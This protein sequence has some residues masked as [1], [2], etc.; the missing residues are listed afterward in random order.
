[1]LIL[2]TESHHEVTLRE[3]EEVL[4]YPTNLAVGSEAMSV[5][6]IEL[7]PGIDM[8]LVEYWTIV[9]DETAFTDD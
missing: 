5:E 9:A 2:G 3:I 1:M 6:M 4:G 7:V 8:L